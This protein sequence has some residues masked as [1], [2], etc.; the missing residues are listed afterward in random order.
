MKRVWLVALVILVCLPANGFGQSLPIERFSA[1]SSLAENV[2]VNPYGQVG[3]QWVGANLNL[4]VQNEAL[5]PFLNIGSMDIALKDANFWTGIVGISVV[6]DEKYS[7]FAAAGGFLNRPFITSAIVP[8]TLGPGSTSADLEF[9]NTKVESWFVQTGIGLG[10]VLLGLYWDHLA[11]ALG[12]PRN[13]NGPIAN[14]TLRGDILSKTFAPFIGLALP[15]GGAMLTVTYSPWA[16]SNT[17]LALMS[18]QNRLSELRYTWNKP[19]DLI[20]ATF[21]YNTP[22]SSSTSFGLW[23]N[24]SWMRMRGEAGLEFENT[25]PTVSRSREVTATMTKYVI[26]GGVTLGINF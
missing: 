14:Q 25:A 23:G 24:Y 6:A 11:F 13:Q 3:F 4:P 18:S 16:Y 15:A 1:L 22:V 19:G 26:G 17:A 21:Q 7:L 8:V 12:D 9:T 2:K 5:T 20:N 10:P